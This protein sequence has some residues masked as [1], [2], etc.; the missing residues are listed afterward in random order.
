[1][2]L[3]FDKQYKLAESENFDEVMKALGV[4]MVTRKMGNAVSPV[5]E[6]TKDG[7][8]YTLKSSSTFKN[9]V[10]TFK[11]GEEFE[12]ETPDGRKVKSTI[13]QDGN[14]LHHIQKGE[15]TTT[16]VR[17]F[18]AEEVKMTITVDDLVCTRIYKAI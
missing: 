15:K 14:K 18:S 1:M 5:I 16:I 4:G 2:S 8:T 12:E 9:T 10:I 13:T 17:E 11:L 3:V 7:D 6:L